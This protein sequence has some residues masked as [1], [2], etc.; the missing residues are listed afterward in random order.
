MP[1]MT[2]RGGGGGVAK[3]S[4]RQPLSTRLSSEVV[5]GRG[6]RLASVVVTSPAQRR[7][8]SRAVTVRVGPLACLGTAFSRAERRAQYAQSG[9]RA[10]LLE[11]A[12]RLLGA[13]GVQGRVTTQITTGR[14]GGGGA[15]QGDVGGLLGSLG[16]AKYKG[17]FAR[18]E[19]D[20][21][22]LSC[23]TD[24]DLQ[25]MGIPMVRAWRL[26][27]MGCCI[28]A[29]PSTSALHQPFAC[30]LHALTGAWGAFGSIRLLAG[31]SQEDSQLL[32]VK[33]RL[34]VVQGFQRLSARRQSRTPAGYSAAS[35]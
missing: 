32:P 12:R 5:G 10:L 1:V 17:L 19:V 13:H 8:V 26:A 22:A 20:M 24:S 14:G 11:R 15:G 3:T 25:L 2:T 4:R 16:L 35:T 7:A 21:A 27:S 29:A 33:L 23:M 6:A 28:G 31:P 18:E 34:Q 9:S 30:W